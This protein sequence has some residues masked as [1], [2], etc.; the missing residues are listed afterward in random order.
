MPMKPLCNVTEEAV[1]VSILLKE[2]FECCLR[3]VRYTSGYLKGQDIS[4]LHICCLGLY[5]AQKPCF[6]WETT[7]PNSSACGLGVGFPYGLTPPDFRNQ[8][9]TQAWPIRAAS[10]SGSWLGK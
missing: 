1:L 8:H 5:L 6:P 4:V 2:Y 9:V 3:I 10:P 7:S